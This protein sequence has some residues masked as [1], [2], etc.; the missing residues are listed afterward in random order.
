MSLPITP[1]LKYVLNRVYGLPASITSLTG[2]WKTGKT[3]FA[4]TLSQYVRELG[5]ITNIASNVETTSPPELAPVKFI[6]NFSSFDLW[7]YSDNQRKMFL[8]D[9]VVESAPSRGAMT[10]LNVGWVRRIPQLSKGRCHLV[11]I[12][13]EEN[14]GDSVFINPSFNR[15]T[16]KKLQKTVVQFHSSF[17]GG[18][19]FEF[20]NLPKTSI[21]FDPYH[22][23]SF[24]M[25]NPNEYLTSSSI[26][27]KVLVMYSRGLSLGKIAEELKIDKINP[28]QTVLRE[29]RRGIRAILVTMSVHP[30]D[31]KKVLAELDKSEDK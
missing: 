31:G 18:D 3:D 9:E 12:T 7:L 14:L 19:Y 21:N 22:P 25:E 15:G 5:L 13:Q 1:N 8:Y 29:L 30:S 20:G 28:R 16:W 6:D 23:A 26:P 17:M 11:A 24:H 27:L 10:S 4:L 2:L